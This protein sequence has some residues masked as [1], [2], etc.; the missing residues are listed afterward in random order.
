MKVKALG[1]IEPRGVVRKC[2]SHTLQLWRALSEGSVRNR[3]AIAALCITALA[4]AT[5]AQSQRSS[6]GS[7]ILGTLSVPRR[8]ISVFGQRIVYYEAGRGQPLILLAHLG[9]DS[10]AWS[11]NLP[12]L[13]SQATVFP[14]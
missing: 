6:H 4:P 10:N 3:I 8:A 12:E 2:V 9:W 5:A 7:P 14:G 1:G 11:Q 13:G